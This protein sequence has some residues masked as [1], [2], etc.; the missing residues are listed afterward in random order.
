MRQ[1]ILIGFS[2]TGKSTLADKIAAQFPHRTKFD[3]DKVITKDFG[4]SIANVYYSRTNID[5]THRLITELEKTVLDT[6]TKEDNNLIIAAGP[7]IPFRQ[8]FD[9]YIKIKNPHVVLIERPAEEIFDSLLDRR[10]EMKCK[11]EHQNPNF[12]IWDIGVMVNEN[13]VDYPK[14]EAIQK[15]SSLLKQRQESYNRFSTLRINSSDIF[16]ETLPE[17]MLHVI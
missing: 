13:L 9:N 3:T 17:S 8:G 16:K 5:D 10:N 14:D 4:G 2:T 12:G 11:S 7:G 1:I 15:I 6:L